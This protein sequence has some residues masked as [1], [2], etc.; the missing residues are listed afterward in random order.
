MGDKATSRIRIIGLVGASRL[1]EIINV[2][3]TNLLVASAAITL[4]GSNKYL[5][6]IRMLKG[7]PYISRLVIVFLQLR[8]CYQLTVGGELRKNWTYIILYAHYLGLGGHNWYLFRYLFNLPCIVCFLVLFY[9]LNHIMS[10][11][12]SLDNLVSRPIM[13]IIVFLWQCQVFYHMF[14]S[15]LALPI[16]LEH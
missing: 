5:Q 16:K 10:Q 9:P 13:M 12:Y 15:H 2:A 7:S 8:R 1:E 11:S 14:Q 3:T 6:H 4:S